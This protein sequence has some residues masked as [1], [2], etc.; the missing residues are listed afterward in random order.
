S[1]GVPGRLFRRF[2]HGFS[3]EAVRGWDRGVSTRE[4]KVLSEKKMK[5]KSIAG[6]HRLGNADRHR[7]G[8]I[9]AMRWQCRIDAGA[10]PD[11]CRIVPSPSAIVTSP[12]RSA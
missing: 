1:T 10:L 5:K 12:D 3:R 8:I 11:R 4:P 2:W 6:P 9:P 7:S